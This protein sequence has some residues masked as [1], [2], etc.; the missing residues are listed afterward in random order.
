MTVAAAAPGSGTPT[1]TVQFQVNGKNFG[2]VVT[3]VGGTATGG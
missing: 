3:L 2:S 1:G